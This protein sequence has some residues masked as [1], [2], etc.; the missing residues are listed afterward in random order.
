MKKVKDI[1]SPASQGYIVYNVFVI[2]ERFS[3]ILL[4]FVCMSQINLI[5][6]GKVYKQ[7]YDPGN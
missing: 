3:G 2:C 1:N 5:L 7:A 4:Y 6:L